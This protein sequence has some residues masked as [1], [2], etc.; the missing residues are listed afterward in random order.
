MKKRIHKRAEESIAKRIDDNDKTL[1]K[2][3]K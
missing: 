1:N 3:F 2:R